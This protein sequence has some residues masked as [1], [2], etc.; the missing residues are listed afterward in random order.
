MKY[1]HLS[2][3]EPSAVVGESMSGEKNKDRKK[4]GLMDNLVKNRLGYSLL[5]FL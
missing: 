4:T 3:V 5:C 2:E 1:L